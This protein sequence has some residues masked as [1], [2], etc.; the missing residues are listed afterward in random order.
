MR[1][2]GAPSVL[3]FSA[4]RYPRAPIGDVSA[5]SAVVALSAE[6]HDELRDLVR[7]VHHDTLNWVPCRGANSIATIITHVLGSEAEA[8]TT[9]AG[10]PTSRDRDSEFRRGGQDHESV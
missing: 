6:V 8:L 7:S 3:T 2:V 4:C 1:F 5:S 10:L 9:V